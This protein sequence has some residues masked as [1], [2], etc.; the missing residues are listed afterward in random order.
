MV[1]RI[2]RSEIFLEALAS[3][4]K[5]LAELKEEDVRPAVSRS[6]KTLAFIEKEMA[7]S[8]AEDDN[9]VWNELSRYIAF[10]K[11]KLVELMEVVVESER[12]QRDEKLEKMASLEKELA[13]L[14]E[15]LNKRK[16]ENRK[17]QMKIGSGEHKKIR[18]Q[19][20]AI[21]VRL[22]NRNNRK[23]EKEDAL[24]LF[25]EGKT[26]NDDGSTNPILLRRIEYHKRFQKHHI[27]VTKERLDSY[28]LTEADLEFGRAVRKKMED[29]KMLDLIHETQPGRNMEIQEN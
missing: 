1:D 5:D 20:E 6:W 3:L 26:Q 17:I 14:K 10:L 7:E 24:R 28:V 4:W 23:K 13:E 19:V 8:T 22:D 12:I 9:S 16:E 15:T 27:P 11:E 21:R 25:K 18:E 2:E 29:E